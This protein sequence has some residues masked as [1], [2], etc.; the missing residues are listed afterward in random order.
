M[1]KQVKYYYENEVELIAQKVQKQLELFENI[2]IESIQKQL[3]LVKKLKQKLENRNSTNLIING[4]TK[5]ED[6]DK[7]ITNLDN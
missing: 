6:Y 1:K 7:V 4:V 5:K 2:T 3:N